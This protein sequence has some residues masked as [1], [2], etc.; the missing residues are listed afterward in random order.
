[1]SQKKP[2]VVEGL[3]RLRLLVGALGERL[4][5]WPSRFTDEVGL[6]RLATPFPRTALRATVESVTLVARHDHDQRLHPRSVHLFRLRGDQEDVIAHALAQASFLLAAP[7]ATTDQILSALDDIG[8]P[9]DGPPPVGP[10]S[11]GAAQR[12]RQNA[13]LAEIARAYSSSA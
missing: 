4:G 8:R 3:A 9:G 6:R 11:L 13:A 2:T 7:P 1:M 10:C 12:T 5:W